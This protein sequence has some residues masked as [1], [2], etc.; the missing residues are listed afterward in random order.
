M[1]APVSLKELLVVREATKVA[2]LKQTQLLSANKQAAASI[3]SRLKMQ[4]S[5]Q[6]DS[7]EIS[8]KSYD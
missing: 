4:L 1:N 3:L 5:S 7:V 8:R 2:E 6:V